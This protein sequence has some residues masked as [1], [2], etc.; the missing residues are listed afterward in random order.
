MTLSPLRFLLPLAALVASGA[1]SAQLLP[2]YGGDRA[3]TSGFQFLEVAVDP[4]G[5]ALGGTAVATADD[6]SALFWNPALAARG[7]DTQV[8][9]ARLAYFADVSMNYAAVT[10]KVGAFTVG[11]HIQSLDS[12]EMPVTDEFSGP[13]GTGQTFSYV[14]IVG[15]L[16]LSQALTDVFSYGVTAKYVRESAAEVTMGAPLLDLGVHYRVG[17][18]GAN[19]GIAI[20]NFGLNGV[21]SG[22][23]P[24][25]TV[26]GETV[27]ESDFEDL[28]PPT[29]FLLGMSYDL[30]RGAGD[31]ALTVSG[32]LTNPNDNAEQFNVG[33]EYVFADLLALRA[34]YAFGIDEGKL[35]TFGF[36]VNIPGLGDRE[37]HADYGF[38]QLDRLG[39]THRVGITASF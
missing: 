18:T 3:G 23:L 31:H 36:G 37:V 21:A 19:I 4:R 30:L 6:A 1:A 25:T 8:G 13:N 39:T 11:A 34:G 16:T 32:Q 24:R 15:G 26:G 5:A 7:G 29:T 10:R 33:A 38:A 28:V 12:G 22:D 35:P 27:T 17:E 14:G 2:S 9:L 20:R